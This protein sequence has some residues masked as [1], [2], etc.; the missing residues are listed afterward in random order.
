MFFFV[1]FT[2]LVM[3]LFMTIEEYFLNLLLFLRTGFIYRRCILYYDF[4]IDFIICILLY[5]IDLLYYLKFYILTRRY[6]VDHMPEKSS[7]FCQKIKI[8]YC[9]R[10]NKKYNCSGPQ[11][12]K[13]K[14]QHISLTKNYRIIVSIQT[15]TSMHTFILKIQLILESRELKDHCHL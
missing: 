5:Y 11:H 9:F 8:T 6:I 4:Y 12:L 15:I 13:V 10:V 14:Q 1:F 3:Y 2:F 7:S